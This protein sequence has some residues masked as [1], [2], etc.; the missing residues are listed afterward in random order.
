MAQLT[1]ANPKFQ[2]LKT[3]EFS[4]IPKKMKALPSPETSELKKQAPS[5]FAFLTLM[6]FGIQTFW[7]QC[8]AL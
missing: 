1:K 2:H 3:P 5:I 6:I 7:K 8:I 4:T